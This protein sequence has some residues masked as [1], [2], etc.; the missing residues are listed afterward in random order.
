M[1]RQISTKQRS[2]INTVIRKA[3][4]ELKTIVVILVIIEVLH[5]VI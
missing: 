1:K 4:L 5:I 2:N 3:I